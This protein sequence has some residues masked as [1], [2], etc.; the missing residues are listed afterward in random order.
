VTHPRILRE[1]KRSE[2]DWQ[3]YE[4]LYGISERLKVRVAFYDFPPYLTPA[5]KDTGF[6]S[7][8]KAGRK[9]LELTETFNNTTSLVMTMAH[10]IGHA[11]S[12]TVNPKR[13]DADVI[14]SAGPFDV[15]REEEIAWALGEMILDEIGYKRSPTWVKLKSDSLVSHYRAKSK[16]CC[17]SVKMGREWFSINMDEVTVDTKRIRAS[18]KVTRLLPNL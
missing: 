1:A 2:Y 3:A 7:R 14:A 15:V 9:L 13:Y 8:S 5:P 10:E 11:I 6:F 17:T 4:N 18:A 16:G 12:C